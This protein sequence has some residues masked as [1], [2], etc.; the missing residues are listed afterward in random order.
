MKVS[1]R[2]T[3]AP[4]TGPARPIR[5]AMVNYRDEAIVGGSLRVGETIVNHVDPRRIATEL[6]FAYGQAGPVSE[7][8][9]VPCHF[10]GAKGPKDFPAW[11][12]ARALFRK[13]KP[14]IIHFQDGVVWLRAALSGTPYTKLVHVHARYEGGAIRSTASAHRK[15]PYAS[16]L[17][18]QAFLKSTGAQVCINHGARNAL[19]ELGWIDSERSY[20]VY[21]SIDVARFGSLPE[22]AKAR[23]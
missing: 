13:L 6:V 3:S 9:K 4:D 17:L 21:N 15:H 8:T 11:V 18:L 10:I 7:N 1:F 2:K 20:V 12:R 19:L 22:R 14:D 23:A 5:V 16:S